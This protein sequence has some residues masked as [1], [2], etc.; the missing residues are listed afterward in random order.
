MERHWR[1]AD[2]PSFEND[3]MGVIAKGMTARP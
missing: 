3:L 2:K 1:V